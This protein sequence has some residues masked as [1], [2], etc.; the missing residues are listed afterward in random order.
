[1]MATTGGINVLRH[2][3]DTLGVRIDPHSHEGG[4]YNYSDVASLLDR[5]GV[6]GSTVIGG[7]IWDPSLPQFQQWDR[8]RGPV[9]GQ[10]YPSAVWRG[11]IL[12]GSGTPNHVND[13]IVSGVWRP[14]DRSRY[15]EDD[16]RATSPPS[17]RSET[18]WPASPNSS[19]SP[20]E[21]KCPRHAC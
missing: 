5:L 13:P 9:A 7:H 18:N 12:M 17:E 8:F 1:M 11:D 10:R 2:L 6:G 3:R 4:G 14:R 20:Q 21:D 15:F 19:R 16:L